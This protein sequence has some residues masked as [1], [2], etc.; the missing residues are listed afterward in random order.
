MNRKRRIGKIV[1]GK[2]VVDGAGVKLVRVLGHRDVE[3]FDLFFVTEC[4]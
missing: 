3:D 4:L 1:T 2:A